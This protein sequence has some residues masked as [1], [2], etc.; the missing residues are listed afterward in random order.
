MPSPGTPSYPG[1]P[2]KSNA[3][4]ILQLSISNFVIENN[5]LTGG[6]YTIYCSSGASVRNNIF[7]REN[8]GWPDKEERR[9]RSGECGQW[10]GNVWEDTGKPL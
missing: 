10:S 2:Y 3:T 5:W 1:A 7:G 9:I 6:N 4:F 8:G